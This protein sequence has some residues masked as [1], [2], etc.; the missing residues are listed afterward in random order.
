MVINLVYIKLFTAPAK[1]HI[2]EPNPRAVRKRAEP[3]NKSLSQCFA[4]TLD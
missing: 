2:S 3:I 4:M 1:H